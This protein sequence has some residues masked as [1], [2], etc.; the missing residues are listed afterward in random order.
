M[1]QNYFRLNTEDSNHE[2][3]CSCVTISYNSLTKVELFKIVSVLNK[4][5][6]LERNYVALVQIKP[7][8][9]DYIAHD[10]RKYIIFSYL[11]TE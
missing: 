5:I 1:T 2:N 8:I 10:F 9:Y 11:K 7:V 3:E 6:S 4:Q